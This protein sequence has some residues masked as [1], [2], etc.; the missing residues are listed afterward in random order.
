MTK[1][2]RATPAPSVIDRDWPHQVALPDDICTD[3][4]F[5]MIA[6]FCQDRRLTF[7]TRHVQAIWTNGKYENYRLH[8]FSDDAAARAFRDHFDGVTFEPKRDRENGNVKGVW[9]R[10]DEYKQM[11]DLGPLSVPEILRN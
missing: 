10:T 11:L 4:N 9:R 5:T 7:Q 6:K 1:R 8:C 3:R 2:S